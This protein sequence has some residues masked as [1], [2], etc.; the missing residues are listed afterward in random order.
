MQIYRIKQKI[1]R[2]HK[3]GT[4]MLRTFPFITLKRTCWQERI[5]FY[6]KCQDVRYS[7]SSLSGVRQCLSQHASSVGSVV[8][9]INMTTQVSNPISDLQN[10]GFF[11]W[12]CLSLQSRRNMQQKALF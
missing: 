2:D 12:R 3:P 9:C 5:P 7:F 11:C 8:L 4:V 10:H 1:Y 6:E